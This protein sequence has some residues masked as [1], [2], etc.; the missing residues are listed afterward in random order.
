MDLKQIRQHTAKWRKCSG[1]W[2]I[3]MMLGIET[4]SGKKEEK[5]KM[6]ELNI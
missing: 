4:E 1:N 5:G 6:A 2:R 3:K